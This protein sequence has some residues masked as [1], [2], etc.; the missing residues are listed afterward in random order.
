MFDNNATIWG[1]DYRRG[2][3]CQM[4]LFTSYTHHSERQV[5]TELSLIPTLSKSLA[6]AM[7]S[8]SSLVGPW[9]RILTQ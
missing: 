7:S 4:D 9:Q 3:N 1:C 8:Q 2:M 6:H 5:I